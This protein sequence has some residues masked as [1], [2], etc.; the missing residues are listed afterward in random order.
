[1]SRSSNRIAVIVVASA[2]LFLGASCSG[3]K[4]NSANAG[5]GQ[6]TDPT[7]E[8]PTEFPDPVGDIPTALAPNGLPVLP[9]D[10]PSP[11]QIAAATAAWVPKPMSEI[12]DLIAREIAG[13]PTQA[14]IDAL[15][16]LYS[17]TPTPPDPGQ[18]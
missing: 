8:D 6:V 5:N 9:G 18:I 7:V 12:N 4:S 10:P 15:D 3:K 17:E 1:M 16:L 14:E 11:S 13:D 2:F